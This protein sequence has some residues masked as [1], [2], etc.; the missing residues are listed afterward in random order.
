MCDA[1]AK[2]SFRPA[3]SRLLLLC[4]LTI[5]WPSGT[6]AVT[7][8]DDPRGFQNIPWG[9]P[10]TDRPDLIVV[11]ADTHTTDYAFRDQP[12]VYADITVDNIQLS[13]VDAQF[14]RVTIRYRGSQTHAQMIRFL[15]RTYG[16][17]ER[18]PGQMMRGL[19]QQYTWRGPDTE[20]SLTYE[21]ARDRGFVF[22]ESRTLAPRFQDLMSD[23]AE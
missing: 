13:T 8:T 20:I 9:A 17:I 14:A 12:P 11:R 1:P 19:N 2:R 16:A 23:T 22:I 3:L 6:F 10:L 4:A 18:I 21:G 5:G 15:E 7:M